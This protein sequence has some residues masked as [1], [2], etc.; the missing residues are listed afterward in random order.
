MATATC[1][2]CRDG[3]APQFSYG[4]AERRVT[5]YYFYLWDIDFGPAFLKVCAYFPYPGKIWINGHEWAKRQASKLG[6]A[7]TA[8]SN[9]FASSSEPQVLQAICDRLGPRT[10]GVFLERSWARL[11]LPLTAADRACGYWWECS[12]RQVEVSR[13]LVFDA[14]RSGRAFF[15]A[16]V[17]D[18][19]D[20]GR[21]DTMELIFGRQVRSTTTGVFATRVVTRGVDVTI[22]AFY[23]HSRIKQY[24]KE[25]R[26]REGDAGGLECSRGRTRGGSEAAT[27]DRRSP[28]ADE[29]RSRPT[30]RG[31]AGAT[32]AS[33]LGDDG[34]VSAVIPACVVGSVGSGLG[35]TRRLPC[36]PG[37]VDP[38]FGGTTKTAP[39]R[40][41]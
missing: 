17:A 2:P 40:V 37:G 25:G 13:T 20:L 7:F 33:E 29:R 31:Q 38:P 5:C 30:S 4:R 19:L 21:P 28:G 18:N 10:I 27:G 15:E 32:G 23:K 35:C 8:L 22:N 39:R 14:P 41:Q 12:M 6:V 26:A 3:G 24:F 34:G 11:P 1:R 36:S 9:G 16:L